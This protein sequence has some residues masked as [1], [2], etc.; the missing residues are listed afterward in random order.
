MRDAIPELPSAPGLMAWW[1][2]DRLGSIEVTD[3]LA[4]WGGSRVDSRLAR[5]A[6]VAWFEAP[7]IG[8]ALVLHRDLLR[9]RR[10]PL[11]LA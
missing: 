3:D 2:D 11:N 4:A 9:E 6:D 7:S 5:W 1:I 8:A 10:P